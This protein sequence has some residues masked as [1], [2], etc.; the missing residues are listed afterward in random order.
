MIP[1]QVPVDQESIRQNAAFLNELP[2]HFDFDNPNPFEASRAAS[3][4]Y[5]T[6]PVARFLGQSPRFR[7]F[8]RDDALQLGSRSGSTSKAA[9]RP[10]ALLGAPQTSTGADFSCD[11]VWN[12]FL[13]AGEGDQSYF[14]YTALDFDGASEN[15]G[16]SLDKAFSQASWPSSAG[17]ASE[18]IPTPTEAIPEGQD[19]ASM[20]LV[21]PHELENNQSYRDCDRGVD[22]SNQ[23]GNASGT[24]KCPPPLAAANT[25]ADR[26]LSPPFQ[27]F[28]S[29]SCPARRRRL[30]LCTAISLRLTLVS[31]AHTPTLVFVV[32]IIPTLIFCCLDGSASIPWK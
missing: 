27:D 23:T 15:D 7:S 20:F 4:G 16:F 29:F 24:C 28:V 1:Q 26:G 31:E 9:I 13:S 14:P 3:S 2:L 30:H 12:D 17:K 8:S 25:L 22:S 18:L 11:S 21:Q 6:A 32:I 5:A 10:D 19:E